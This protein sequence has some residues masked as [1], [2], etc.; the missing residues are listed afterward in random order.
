[1]KLSTNFFIDRL[2]AALP[3]SMAPRSDADCDVCTKVGKQGKVV[4][5]LFCMTCQKNLCD[6][7][8][9]IHRNMKMTMSHKLSPVIEISDSMREKFETGFCEKHPQKN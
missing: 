4:A 1:M 2:I 8:C 6:E 7:C 9:N 5:P 3:R